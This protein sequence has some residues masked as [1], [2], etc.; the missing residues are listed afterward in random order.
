MRR[1]SEAV[2][3]DVRRRMNPPQRQSVARISKELGIHVM[4]LYSW[5]KSWRLQ[6]EVPASE[7]EPEGWDARDKFTLVL[8]TAGLNTTELSSYCREG[9]YFL[10]RWTVG[11]RPP[12]MPMPSRC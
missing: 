5:R 9:A 10:S 3:A 4:T 11:A 7:K 12:K 2:R 6:G 8:E 1:Y